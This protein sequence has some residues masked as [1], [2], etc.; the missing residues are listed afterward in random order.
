MKNKR[1]INNLTNMSLIV[2][3]YVQAGNNLKSIYGTLN[4]DI[5]PGASSEVEYG[6][7]RNGYLMGLRVSPQPDDPL[8]T[9]YAVVKQRDDIIDN[10]LNKT[11]AIDITIERLH[12]SMDSHSPLSQK[13]SDAAI[14]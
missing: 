11:N 7:L 4:V 9:Y 2:T 1:M 8:E 3:L 5:K 13:I 10:W 6:D 14:S 12:T